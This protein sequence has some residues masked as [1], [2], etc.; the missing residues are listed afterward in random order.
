ME[1]SLEDTLRRLQTEYLDFYYLHQPDYDVP[2]EET[3]ETLALMIRKG[4]V[5]FAASSNYASWQVCQMLWIA[6]KNGYQP[7][8]VTQPMYNL[9]ARGVEQEYVPMARQF[10]VSIIAYN[11]LAGGLLT[12]KHSLSQPAQGS[13][14]VDNLVYRDRYWHPQILEAVDKLKT[15]ASQA[16]R[17]LT[18][19]ALNWLLH[20]TAT[21]CVVLGASRV[22]QL[23]TNLQAI[24]DGPLTSDTVKQCDEVWLWLRGC[25]PQYNR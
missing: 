2:L 20:H 8:R 5:R 13:R 24:E 25:T 17:S 9:L 21:A 19:L 3:L 6:E 15:I 16:G 7:A 14:F 1:K 23:K 11:P 12:G 18:S 4:K 10:G 22:G